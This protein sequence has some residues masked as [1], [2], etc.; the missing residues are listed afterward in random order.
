MIVLDTNVLSALMRAVPQPSV[1][2]WINHQAADSSFEVV[3]R[4]LWTIRRT[5]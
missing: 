2:T 1:V 4:A 3:Q 5:D